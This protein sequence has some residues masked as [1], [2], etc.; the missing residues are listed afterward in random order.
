MAIIKAFKG[1][2]P[3]RDVAEKI[4]SRPYDVLSSE[5]ALAESAGNPYS[6]YHI[7]KSEIDLPPET[8]HYSPV[9]YEQAKSTLHRFIDEGILVQDPLPCLYVYAQ[10]MWGRTQ[11][12]LVACAAVS[13]YL[14]N[15]IKKHELTRTDKEIDR[16]THIRVTNFNTE[17]VFFAY[18]DHHEINRIVKDHTGNTPE[19]DFEAGDGIR[20]RLWVISNADAVTRIVNIFE[21]E[22]PNT[23]IA[24]GH[25]RTAAAAH[26]GEERRNMNKGHKGDEE[27]NFF[28]AV[29][30]PASQLAILDYN[31]VVKDLNGYTVEQFLEKL[32]DVFEIVLLGEK[33][34]KPQQH[35]EFSLY[36]DGK[37]YALKAQD[38]HYDDH[39]PIGCLDVTILSRL[40]FEPILNIRDLRNS[41]RIDFVGGIRG[42]EALRSRVDSGEMA[43]AFALYPV[44]MDQLIRI[45][46]TG[47]IMPPKV[48][49]FEPKLR[50]GLV[51]HSLE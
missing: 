43:A 41:H 37:W 3:G 21:K 47:N 16:K 8:D 34:Y 10:T 20:H 27:Y 2:R 24:D 11:Y 44:S 23:Y 48:T 6:F 26:V 50:S 25:H 32:G 33:E 51:L 22:I 5:E 30:F 17:P 12:G 35:H 9:V 31:R 40:V 19:Y 18:R 39:D 38:C 14:G 36:L 45:A 7:I 49:W 15:V 1:F 4:A 46:D 28:L 42:L 13:D 29:H